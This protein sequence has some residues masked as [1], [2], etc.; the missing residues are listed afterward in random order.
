MNNEQAQSSKEVLES[1]EAGQQQPEGA[2]EVSDHQKGLIQQW[3]ETGHTTRAPLF[4]VENPNYRPDQDEHDD[5]PNPK[6]I[7]IWNNRK[8]RKLQEAFTR[9]AK[10]RAAKI[11]DN[12]YD[13]IAKKLESGQRLGKREMRKIN[14]LRR[15]K[16]Q[17]LGEQDVS[18]VQKVKKLFGFNN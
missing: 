1:T 5:R 3:F 13:V 10:A 18:F 14:Q 6:R 2:A 7:L 12:R 8:Q 4:N 15:S 17:D 16:I 9:R 11:D